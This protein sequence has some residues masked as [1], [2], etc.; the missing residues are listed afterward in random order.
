M[1]QPTQ[2][3]PE[4][5]Q[6]HTLTVVNNN[7]V[8][9]ETL[10][11]VE[12]GV[13]MIA[14]YTSGKGRDGVFIEYDN[15]DNFIAENGT[16]NYAL[17]GQPI[18]MPYVTLKTGV[19]KVW[20]MRV[21]PETA[22]YANLA[23]AAK[24]KVDKTDVANPKLIIRFTAEFL[25]NV[26]DKTEFESLT[27]L[28][29][30]LTPDADG[31]TTYPIFT[32]YTLGRGLYGNNQRIRLLS[33]PQ[34]D[35]EVNYKS[36]R[37]ETYE[38]TNGALASVSD[39]LYPTFVADAIVDNM[40]VYF[41]D[42][43]ND[44]ETGSTKV[45][46]YSV[47]GS[48][49][50]IYDLYVKEIDPAT[51]VTRETFDMF[52]GVIKDSSQKLKGIQYD[53]T[54]VDYISLDS[55]AGIPLSGGDDGAF[56]YDPADPAKMA[57]REDAINQAYKDAFTGKTDK[58]ILSKR[59]LPADLILDAG[60]DQEV[61]LD[62]I[63]LFIKR[64]DAVGHLD[65]GI[66]N[67]VSSAVQWG[68]D[69]FAYGDYV[70]SKQF[71]HYKVRDPFSGKLIPVT[72]TYHLASQ[73]PLHFRNNGK[74]IP[75]VG[76][77]LT[78]LTGAQKNSLKPMIDADDLETKEQL[79]DLRLNYYQ[80]VAENVIA[81][82]TQST[83]DTQWSDLSEENNVYVLMELKRKVENMVSSLQYNFA[84]QED[85]NRFTQDAGRL[86][87]PY[88]G[89]EIREG[90]VRFDMNAWE[91]TRSILHCY[92]EIVFRTMA[93]RGIVEIDINPRV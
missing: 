63:Q 29:L 14:V 88:V 90:S 18:Y 25:P 31:F 84:E 20:G 24:V 41:D 92:M 37:F 9:T 86:L 67:T 7:T 53:T 73:L 58:A 56:T 76:T 44:D 69:M 16:L 23:V 51:T 28:M 59:R 19:A 33:A 48:I 47:P 91:E 21:M 17:Y 77:A 87:A 66:I 79:Y 10:P 43:V 35:K 81:R 6:P 68:N 57:L 89:T 71:Q 64:R 75:F 72:M 4:Y 70:Y 11:A 62:L 34:R 60:Y 54:H 39:P 55:P 42:I 85:R 93:K 3:Y 82:G 40:S 74:H 80:S 2:I 46:V 50:A 22:T 49:D 1:P 52:Y 5:R 78:T 32:T 30:D 15:P 13:R 38:L 27:D 61:K 26:A 36:Y 12:D 83:S 45:N 65:A 8:F